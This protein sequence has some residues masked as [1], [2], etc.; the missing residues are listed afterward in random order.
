M[1]L[2]EANLRLVQVDCNDADDV[3]AA[4]T[5]RARAIAE[6]AASASQE[7]LNQTLASGEDF[8]RRLESA[9]AE[10]RQELDRMTNLSRGLESTLDQSEP[11]HVTCFG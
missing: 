8:R 11:D 9:Q 2:R 4:L 10:A 3:D 7:L 6:F 5:E 1:T